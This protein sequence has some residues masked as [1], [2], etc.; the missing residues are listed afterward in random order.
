MFNDEPVEEHLHLK[1]SRIRSC[2][3][4]LIRVDVNAIYK[5]TGGEGNIS[6]NSMQ[7]NFKEKQPTV[8]AYKKYI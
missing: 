7:E 3:R 2:Y 5:E 6:G 4:R 1:K 8:S